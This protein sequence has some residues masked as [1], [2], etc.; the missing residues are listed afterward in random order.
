MTIYAI[1]DKLR[2]PRRKSRDLNN[3]AFGSHLIG[4]KDQI[5][6]SL[7]KGAAR[8]FIKPMVGLFK[9]NANKKPYR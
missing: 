1:T 2:K 5:S 8:F 9:R 6:F 3:L 7:V 4:W